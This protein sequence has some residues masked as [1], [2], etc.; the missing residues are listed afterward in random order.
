[1]SLAAAAGSAQAAST[2]DDTL[3]GW[4]EAHGSVAAYLSPNHAQTVYGQIV[5][6]PLG[7][8][9]VLTQWAMKVQGRASMKSRGK[10]RDDHFTEHQFQPTGVEV[11]P[12]EQ[13]VL[14]LTTLRN[15]KRALKRKGCALGTVKGKGKRVAHQGARAGRTLN[16]GS[17]VS[18]SLR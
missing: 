13:I 6:A 2:T 16:R 17:A 8:R 11:D 10:V 18:V 15:A 14:I 3:S 9:S 7:G 5:T 1:M 4:D 12:G